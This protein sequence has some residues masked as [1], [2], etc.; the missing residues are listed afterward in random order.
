MPLRVICEL[1]F[2]SCRR[3]LRLRFIW[4]TW[5]LLYRHSCLKFDVCRR[6]KRGWFRDSLSNVFRS[7]RYC[8]WL[9]ARNCHQRLEFGSLA[10]VIHTS[11]I[12]VPCSWVVRNKFLV[13]LSGLEY[14]WLTLSISFWRKSL[15]FF[16]FSW[17]WELSV[18]EYTFFFKLVQILRCR[19]RN[20]PFLFFCVFNHNLNF[21]CVRYQ[22]FRTHTF[23]RVI[24]VGL[25]CRYKIW[26]FSKLYESD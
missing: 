26:T 23:S 24:M 10:K 8:N 19:L 11:L 17:G 22:A 7:E 6:L 3:T 1:V 20:S 15:Q 2:V 12:G 18:I 21:F 16:I 4:D 14:L 9:T 25:V 5:T 13:E